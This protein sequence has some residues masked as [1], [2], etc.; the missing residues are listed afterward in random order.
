MVIRKNKK[1][2]II[3]IIT[4]SILL[5]IGIITYSYF[6][7]D[8]FKSDKD[9]FFEYLSQ[10]GD[11]KN[12][13]ID[14][15]IVEYFLKKQ[16]TPYEN[17][18]LIKIHN[19]ESIE[20]VNTF[21]ISFNGKTD[22]YGNKAEQNISLN[23][24][25][26]V[27][28]PIIYRRVNDVL[29]LKTDFVSK[30]FIAIDTNNESTLPDD[31]ASIINE[32]KPIFQKIKQQK[33][34]EEMTEQ[35]IE[36]INK[37]AQVFFHSI[38]KSKFSKIQEGN[39]VG[40]KL[41]LTEKDIK[42]IIVE[43]LT[44]LKDDQI[45]L[46]RIN[47]YMK[48]FEDLNTVDKNY[49][50]TIIKEIENFEIEENQQIEISIYNENRKLSK[51]K[52]LLGTKGITLE[53]IKENNQVSLSISLNTQTGVSY[54]VETNIL[55]TLKLTGLET[56]QNVIENYYV[57]AK[58]SEG[59]E[60]TNE[61]TNNVNFLQNIDVEEFS[62]ENSI[63][64]NNFEEEQVMN[65]LKSVGE[66]IQEVNKLQM[67]ELG[68]E[69]NPLMNFLPISIAFPV[70]S[71]TIPEEKMDEM[72]INAFNFIWIKYEGVQRKKT[73]EALMT[74]L[75]TSLDPEYIIDGLKIEE[76]NFNGEKYEPIAKN[77]ELIKTQINVEK[78]YNVEFEMKQ[79]TGAIYK[80][81]IIEK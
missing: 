75:E 27:K 64:L 81:I 56:M 57:T 77:I 54:D 11:S 12:G 46:D 2:A 69:E 5:L 19:S 24:S 23:Y 32:M 79:D 41:T 3:L 33:N 6:Q 44:T 22:N 47:D 30:D 13:F 17:N 45:A 29:G 73:V 38:E 20:K 63:I 8:F 18:G 15:Q 42:D 72:L 51:I 66:R 9:L 48:K 49:V 1:V 80:I 40:Y 71:S 16:N 50:E 31:I 74:D 36:L 58:S 65:F 7:T 10:V 14:N 76:I 61:L 26:N 4:V 62:E 21:N 78:L 59:K 55:F 52:I 67:E 60:L 43:L 70:S 53:K 34:L 37:Y 28:F 68:L 35:D 25:D 39:S